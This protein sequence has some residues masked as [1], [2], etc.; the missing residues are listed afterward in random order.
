MG[1]KKTHGGKRAGAGRKE[2]DPSEKSVAVTVTVP[3]ELVVQLDELREKE[4]WNRS[5]AFAE[6]IRWLLGKKS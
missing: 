2:K 5:Q 1:K 4:G 6:A 3:N